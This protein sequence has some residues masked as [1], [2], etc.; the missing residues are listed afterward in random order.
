MCVSYIFVLSLWVVE[1]RI[2]YLIPSR[3]KPEKDYET[4]R[5]LVMIDRILAS[6]ASGWEE[7]SGRC[8]LVVVKGAQIT[9]FKARRP[10]NSSRQE[11]LVL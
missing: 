6:S 10:L 1:Y 11:M 7:A 4:G 5:L 9:P 3:F 2:L 8:M